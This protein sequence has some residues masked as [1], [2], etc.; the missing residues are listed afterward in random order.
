MAFKYIRVYFAQL[1]R[2]RERAHCA[3]VCV[4]MYREIDQHDVVQVVE[5]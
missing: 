4:Y 5:V 1:Y 3:C 2:Q